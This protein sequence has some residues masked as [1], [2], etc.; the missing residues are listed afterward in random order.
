MFEKRKSV[1]Y[2]KIIM[3]KQFVVVSD[4]AYGSSTCVQI[5]SNSVKIDLSKSVVCYYLVWLADLITSRK[6]PK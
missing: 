6:K 3:W 1:F 5:G 4:K 2:G